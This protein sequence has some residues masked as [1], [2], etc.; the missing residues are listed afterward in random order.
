MTKKPTSFSI[1]NW[2][3]DDQPRE[4]LRD[5][6]KT[7][8]SDAEL[9]AILIG[10]GNREES[11]V[12]LCKRIFASVDNNLNALGKL[13]IAQLM[14]FK[15]I[16]EA[17]AIAITAALELGRR[18]RLEDVL[19]LDKVTSSRSVF[20]IMQPI[21][22]D[23]PHE[24]FWILYLNN[25]NKVIQKNQ[26]SKGGITG[27]LVDVRLVLKNALEVGATALILCHNHPSETLKPSESDKNVTQKLKVAAQSLD[28][29][30]LDH[31]IIT[32]K[33][34]FSFADENVL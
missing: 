18:R 34:Y 13:S 6:G 17:K 3:Q 14:D 28:L 16:G 5:K 7:A 23:L 1:K 25:S 24:E 10:S 11:A 22:G 27:T 30:V 2:S 31:L 33:A 29:K 19:Q 12:A 15:G 8:L 26:L 32:E 4:K 21:L 9:I 20:D